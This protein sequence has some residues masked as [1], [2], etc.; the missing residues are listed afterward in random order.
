[1]SSCTLSKNKNYPVQDI[2]FNPADK[3]YRLTLA[4]KSAHCQNGVFSSKKL[5]VKVLPDNR[6]PF[7]HFNKKENVPELVLGNLAMIRQSDAQVAQQA[8]S[9]TALKSAPVAGTLAPNN[10][11]LDTRASAPHFSVMSI[12]LA[13]IV[14]VLLVRFFLRRK[15]PSTPYYP[16]QPQ[17]P[18]NMGM[19]PYPYPGNNPNGPNGQNGYPPNNPN[20]PGGPNVGSGK[21]GSFMSGLAGGALGAVVGSALYDKMK[22]NDAEAAPQDTFSS[23]SGF[24]DGSSDSF[25][26]FSDE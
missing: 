2:V 24:D 3:S 12:I 17:N 25:D 13:V 1:M 10:G 5:E 11:L 9:Q 19:G 8:D 26:S 20:G 7:L 14:V 16:G 23:D 22:G 15:A 6:V 18:N 21:T 4:E